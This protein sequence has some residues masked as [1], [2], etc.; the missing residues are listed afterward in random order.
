MDTDKNKEVPRNGTSYIM[1][2]HSGSWR[3]PVRIRKQARKF[4]QAERY[5]RLCSII[6]EAEAAKRIQRRTGGR[7]GLKEPLNKKYGFTGETKAVPGHV[8]HRI[9]ALTS[10][11]DV[12]AGELGGWIEKES[13]LDATG[14]AWISGE[15]QAYGDVWV[16]GS[17][18]ISGYAEITGSAR[19]S[20]RAEIT[21]NT[22]ISGDAV[23]TGSARISGYARISDYAVITGSA[24]IF[25]YAEITGNTRTS[26]D[27][28]ISGDARV[29][30]NA[31][32]YKRGAIFWISA[33]GS[34]N[35]T[36]TFFACMDKKIRV[37]V[38]CFIGG[39]DEFAAAVKKTHGDNTHAKVY[40]LA[41]EMA[42]ERIKMDDMP[43]FADDAEQAEGEDAP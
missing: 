40:R 28:V 36:A 34:R 14:D 6:A 2:P 24:R 21:G 9:R 11:G 12:N 43:S 7:K 41:A 1:A 37:Q 30:G 4:I 19:I 15:A 32:V 39:L 20:G 38:G 42:K 3:M 8:L 26:G 10:F 22:R 27:A 16:F 17:A 29:S 13:N 35:D 5:K 25:G 33:V 31:C 18:R 23:I